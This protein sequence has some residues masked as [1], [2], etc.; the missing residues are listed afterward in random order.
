MANAIQ[1]AEHAK[2]AEHATPMIDAATLAAELNVDLRTV[3]R[4]AARG[5]LPHVR[6][7][8]AVRFRLADVLRVLGR[9]GATGRTTRPTLPPSANVRA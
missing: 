9:T 7:G 8:R 4:Q 2:Q 3:Y 1:H 5:E 6:V